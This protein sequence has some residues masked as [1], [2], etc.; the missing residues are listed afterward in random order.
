V[1]FEALLD[2]W[3]AKY[4]ARTAIERIIGPKA[5][6]A[7]AALVVRGG[8]VVAVVDDAASAGHVREAYGAKADV[9]VATPSRRGARIGLHSARDDAELPKCDLVVVHGEALAG[10]WRG[11]LLA[12]GKLAV[13]LVVVGVENP[14]AWQAEA[15]SLFARVAGG[16]NGGSGWGRTEAL[17]PVL[18]EIGR[19]REHAFLDVPRLATRV[20]RLARRVAPLHAFVIDVTPRSPQARRRLRLETA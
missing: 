8:I 4:D 15:R 14:G 17:A 11:S 20:P 1:N 5:S 9:R 12:L 16:M 18:W 6:P 13:K 2:E 10:D 7:C 3:A 19:V